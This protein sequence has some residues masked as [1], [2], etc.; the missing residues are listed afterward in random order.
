[1]PIY[2]KL[3]RD[4]IPD[5]I[6]KTGKSFNTIILEETDFVEAL[7]KKCFEELDEYTAASTNEEAIEELADLLELMH[8]L[9]KV[10]GASIEKVEEVRQ[11][12]AEKRGGFQ[13][14]IFLL[15]VED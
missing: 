6:K 12:K 9:A 4:R 14:R 13:E 11:Q 1:M 2:K 5:I 7:K 3:V 8:A 10:H 15:D